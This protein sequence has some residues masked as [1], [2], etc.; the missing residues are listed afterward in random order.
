MN[1]N[2]HLDWVSYKNNEKKVEKVGINELGIKSKTKCD[3]VVE[4]ILAMVVRGEYGENEKLPPE[5]YF[6]E[7]FGVSRVT[8]R[9]A[10]K[11]LNMLGVVSICQ[12]KGTFVTKV[13]LGTVM[14]PL[15]SAIVLDNLSIEQ[16]YGARI[17]VES[18]TACLAAK[19]A[20]EEE[21]K[22][23]DRLLDQMGHIVLSRD[24]VRFCEMDIIFH[25]FIGEISRNH[26]LLATYKTIEDVLGN[27]ITGNNLS[28]EII[29]CS[30]EYHKKIVTAIKSGNE[31]EAREMMEKHIKLT[32]NSLIEY[33]SKG[34]FPGY[35]S[36]RS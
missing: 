18:G 24:A 1:L 16:I 30:H 4:E 5:Q 36:I 3:I 13:D 27:Y 10:F 12:G 19:N 20:T 8:V 23:L 15:F 14:Q 35:I 17:Y 28:M 2:L 11:R 25:E 32:Q 7:R 21:L 6:V 9:E 26:I 33:L 31:R 29:E 34:D 22:E